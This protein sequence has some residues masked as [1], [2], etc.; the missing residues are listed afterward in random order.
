MQQPCLNANGMDIDKNSDTSDVELV[1]DSKQESTLTIVI[2]DSGAGLDEV[3]KNKVFKEVF[4][5]K[6]EVLQGGGGRLL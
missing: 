6:P 1:C 2:K 5:F 3:H 4:Q